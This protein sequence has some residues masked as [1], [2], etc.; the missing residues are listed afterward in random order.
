MEQR[1]KRELSS[2]K[3]EGNERRKATKVLIAGEGLLGCHIP[4]QRWPESDP[5]LYRHGVEG[6]GQREEKERRNGG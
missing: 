6:R 1:Q 2:R 5:L 4:T 3:K